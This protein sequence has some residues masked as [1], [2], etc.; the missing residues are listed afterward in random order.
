VKAAGCRRWGRDV[1]TDRGHR[2]SLLIFGLAGCGMLPGF[3]FS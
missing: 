1:E 3:L 2:R